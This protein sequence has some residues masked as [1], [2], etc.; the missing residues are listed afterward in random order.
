LGTPKA[1]ERH[2]S[3]TIFSGGLIM[4]VN[5]SEAPK[6]LADFRALA[7]QYMREHK[8]RWSE[9]CL[10]IK[11]RYGAAA[12]AAFGAPPKADDTR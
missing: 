12:R 3:D 2:F 11:H 6:T 10:A 1:T 8:C 7:E 5:E 9:A 4:A